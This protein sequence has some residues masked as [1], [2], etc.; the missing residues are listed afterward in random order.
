MAGENLCFE[1]SITSTWKD[2]PLGSSVIEITSIVYTETITLFDLRDTSRILTSI[3][4]NN[5][6]LSVPF[7]SYLF[8]LDAT[9]PIIYS[10]TFV[11]MFDGAIDIDYFR[12]VYGF[13]FI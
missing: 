10:S 11:H 8:W 12:F 5:C 3:S 9:F 7:F 1:R 4:K 6:Q 2:F 13:D